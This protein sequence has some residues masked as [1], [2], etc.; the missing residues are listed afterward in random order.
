VQF[1]LVD[2]WDNL[3]MLSTC[4]REESDYTCHTFVEGSLRS[5]SKFL[6]PKFETPIALTFPVAGSF[7]ISCHVLIKFQSGWCFFKSEGSVEQGQCMR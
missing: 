2:S 6:I 4:A 1:D 3:Q 5:F 7:C